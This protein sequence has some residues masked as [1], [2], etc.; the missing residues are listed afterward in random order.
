MSRTYRVLRNNSDLQGIQKMWVFFN[1]R[2]AKKFQHIINKRCRRLD[3]I[4]IAMGINEI[5]DEI[6]E[7]IDLIALEGQHDDWYNDDWYEENPL[8]DLL[9]IEEPNDEYEDWWEDE[10][11]YDSFY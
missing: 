8:E 3:K 5:L 4:A 9:G 2:G 11:Y 7:D 1:K 6:Q 10:E